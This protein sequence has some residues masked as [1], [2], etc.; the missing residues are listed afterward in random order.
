MFRNDT[1]FIQ[2]CMNK[3]LPDFNGKRGIWDILNPDRLFF[4]LLNYNPDSV[5]FK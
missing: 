3:G 2:F 1:W 5:Y 4:H